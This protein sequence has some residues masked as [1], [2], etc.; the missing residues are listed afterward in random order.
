MADALHP[1][2]WR[3]EGS[4]PSRISIM[5]VN[6]YL[7]Q[8]TTDS[9]I[10]ELSPNEQEIITANGVSTFILNK[11]LSKKFRKQKIDPDC[12]LRTELA[13]QTKVASQQPLTIIFPQGGYKLW[14]LPSAPY[15]DWAELFN[16][17]YLL[18]YVSPLAAAYKPGVELKY[19]FHTLLMEA[20]DNLST[21]DISHYVASFESLLVQFKQHLP[22]NIRVSIIKDA[23]IYTRSEYFDTLEAGL[24]AAKQVFDELSPENQAKYLKMAE[25]N[26]KWNGKE[27]WSNL[28]SAERGKKLYKA[29]LYEIAVSRNLPKVVAQVK[30]PD[31]ILIFTISS[32]E[33]IGVGS[34]ASSIAKHW[35]GY[36]VLAKHKHS[37]V[38]VILSPQQF[39]RLDIQSVAT[40]KTSVI[41][42]IN[43]SEIILLEHLP[44]FS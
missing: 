12:K 37:Y 43:F 39:Q 42:Q 5:N 25:L 35:V 2:R 32:K 13:I 1:A 33:F 20:H 30:S 41:D 6:Q 19:Y 34:C 38:P 22:P 31:N 23:D 18:K 10:Y 36:G 11:L 17:S 15:A 16:I 29:A 9:A 28:D 4:S 14:K 44:R 40:E 21:E 7:K 8:L 3:D 24:P 26:I 27:D